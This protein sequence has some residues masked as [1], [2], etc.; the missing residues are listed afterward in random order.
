M[1]AP[2]VLDKPQTV[3]HPTV[4][5]LTPQLAFLPLGFKRESQSPTTEV[6]ATPQRVAFDPRLAKVSPITAFKIPHATLF[7]SPLGTETGAF[8]YNAQ[9]FWE[10][11]PHRGGRHSGDDLNGIA[12][13]NS[14]LGDPVYAIA[15][16]YVVYAATPSIGWG[17]VLLIAHRVQ[18]AEGED[19]FIQSMY[20]HL[21]RFDVVVGQRVKRGQKVGAVGNADGQYLAHLH[22]EMRKGLSLYIG[23]GYLDTPG[24]RIAPTQYLS[25]FLQDERIFASAPQSQPEGWQRLELR[26]V[27]HF[28]NLSE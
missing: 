5:T 28:L 17:K 15:D 3:T 21:D 12:G 26:N 20:A 1:L 4:S 6:F 7:S 9:S 24:N 14:D 18:N 10:E 2:L 25:Q 22:F 8:T 16:G 23:P 27:E 19:E 11:N 13:G